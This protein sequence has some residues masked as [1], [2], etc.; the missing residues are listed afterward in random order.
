MTGLVC[1][2]IASSTTIFCSSGAVTRATVH[3]VAATSDRTTILRCRPRYGAIQRNQPLTGCVVFAGW[4]SCVTSGRWC[5]FRGE[6][7]EG[8]S[9]TRRGTQAETRSVFSR[10]RRRSSRA[11]EVRARAPP[12][13]AKGD[14]KPSTD[15]EDTQVRLAKARWHGRTAWVGTARARMR[16]SCVHRQGRLDT[17]RED[18]EVC[19][20]HPQVVCLRRDTAPPRPVH[21]SLGSCSGLALRCWCRT[22]LSQTEREEVRGN[23]RIVMDGGS[24]GENSTKRPK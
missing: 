22:Y 8:L 20:P 23:A 14:P 4:R 5:G 11:G 7:K 9:W 17:P 2:M 24:V 1:A 19:R 10:R 16:T 3:R 13:S 15:E 6:G 12:P 18:V 21:Q